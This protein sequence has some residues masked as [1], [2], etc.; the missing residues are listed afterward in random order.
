M[1]RWSFK[2]LSDKKVKRDV[3]KRGLWDMDAS[4]ADFVSMVTHQ[5]RTPL[6]GIKWTLSMLLNEELGPINKDQKEWILQ[7][8]KSNEEVVQLID[9]ILTAFRLDNDGLEIHRRETDLVNLFEEIIDHVGMVAKHQ[10]VEVV[11]KDKGKEVEPIAVDSE[12]IGIVFRNLLENAV[13]YSRK[14]G[15]VTV[16]IIEQEGQLKVSVEDNGIGIRKE[17]RGNIFKRFFRAKN[18]FKVHKDGTGLGLYISKS[19]VEKHGGQIWFESEEGK[20]T[21]FYFTLPRFYS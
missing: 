19:I 5:I 8:F 17:D 20:G 16:D 21:T 10:N 11:F 18:A 6:A 3:A 4:Q 7:A 15:K 1:S 13:R 9:E 14:G 12:K 2:L